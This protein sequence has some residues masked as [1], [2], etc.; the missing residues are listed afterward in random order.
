MRSV[1]QMA[2]CKGDVY[3]AIDISNLGGFSNRVELTTSVFLDEVVHRL[4]EPLNS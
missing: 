4:D 2:G 1:L 3:V